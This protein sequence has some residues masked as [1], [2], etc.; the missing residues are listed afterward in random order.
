MDY[1]VLGAVNFKSQGN[2]SFAP[3][4]GEDDLRVGGYELV[5]V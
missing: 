1:S 2:Y 3:E 4:C 5:R